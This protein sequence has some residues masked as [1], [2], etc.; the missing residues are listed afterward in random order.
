MVGGRQTKV[1]GKQCHRATAP[2]KIRRRC[3][4][5]PSAA[6]LVARDR[7]R[8]STTAFLKSASLHP[9]VSTVIITRIKP[10]VF[11]IIINIISKKT[12]ASGYILL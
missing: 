6:A 8:R 3:G 11:V 2:W 10:N 4:G 12:K 7:T 1:I 9:P 5:K